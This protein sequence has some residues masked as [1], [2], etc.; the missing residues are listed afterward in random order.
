MNDLK[1]QLRAVYALLRLA[2]FNGSEPTGC[3]G[4]A[5]AG[6]ACVPQLDRA[7]LFT[8]VLVVVFVDRSRGLPTPRGALGCLGRGA[9]WL[10]LSSAFLPCFI[11]FSWAMVCWVHYLVVL[12]AAAIFGLWISL[13]KNG[14]R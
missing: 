7:L 13:R 10:G 6:V 4:L 11:R 14:R 3:G 12:F 8:S 1:L 9:P 5:L 2:C